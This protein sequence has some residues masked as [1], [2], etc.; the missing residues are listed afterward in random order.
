MFDV[1][2]SGTLNISYRMSQLVIINA[3]SSFTFIWSLVK[4]WLA[5][6]TV[7]K[8]EIL[9]SDYKQ[10]MLD[11][12]E[13]DALPVSLGGT[14]TCEGL[15]GCLLSGVGPWLEG[16]EGW[17]PNSAV[18]QKEAHDQE[19]KQADVKSELIN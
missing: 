11:V 17:G 16:R 15:G 5:V 1:C 13:P 3:P 6:E 7:K 8:V 4:P 12:A 2:Y 10:F 19:S 14:C 9:G 18:K